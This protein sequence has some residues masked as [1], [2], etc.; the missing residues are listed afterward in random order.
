M[1]N[2]TI[3]LLATGLMALPLFA[4]NDRSYTYLALG[5]SIPFG[6]DITKLPPYASQLPKPTDFVGYPEVIAQTEHVTL[7]N[8]SCPGESSA[9]F[10]NV[11]MPDYGCNSPH[12]QPGD[13]PPIPPFKSL[14]L[15]RVSYAGSQ[16]DFALDQVK[17][18]KNINLVTLNIGANDVFLVLPQLQQCTTKECADGVLGPVLQAYAANLEEILTGI[19]KHYQGKLVLMKYYSPAPALDGVAVAVNDTMTAVV[20]QLNAEKHF[21]DVLLADGFTAFQALSAGANHDACQAGLLIR[22]PTNPPPPQP[23]DIHPS[24]YGRNVLAA[25]VAFALLNI[26]TN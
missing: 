20:T 9:S 17:H 23:C 14:N 25:T 10:L 21:A 26:N 1:N 19:R 8:P 4:A 15:L 5:D 7:L 12:P 18:N 24:E 3:A 22:L 6:M 11:N 13:L 2:K 16:M